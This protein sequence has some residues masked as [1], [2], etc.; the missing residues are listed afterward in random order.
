MAWIAV[1]NISIKDEYQKLVSTL[2]DLKSDEDITDEIFAEVFVSEW[3]KIYLSGNVES[4]EVEIHIEILTPTVPPQES[5]ISEKNRNMSFLLTTQIEY[6]EYLLRLHKD[7]GFKL[8]I[9]KEEGIWFGT[10]KL[11]TEPR[12]KFISQI[13]PPKIPPE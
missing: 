6:L 8:E 11:E 2:F 13:M 3:I 10:K 4:R 12:E 5:I 9:I 7:N 1:K